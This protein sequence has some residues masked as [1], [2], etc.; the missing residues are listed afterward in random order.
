M[1]RIRPFIAVLDDEPQFCKA[2]GRLLKTHGFEVEMFT[3]GEEL[4]AVCASRLPDCLL[5][6]LHMPRVNG[7]EVLERLVALRLKVPVVVITGHDQPGNADRVRALGA[8]A[9]LLK[10]VNDQTVIDAI[11]FALDRES[12]EN[13]AHGNDRT[14][15]SMKTNESRPLI[16]AVADEE[17]IRN[18][19]AR[20]RHTA[21]LDVET[22]GIG[23]GEL[24]R[25]LRGWTEFQMNLTAARLLSVLGLPA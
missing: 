17:C 1:D 22:T 2:V 24:T 21:V 9:Y 19:M 23:A 4:L 20:L 25:L 12:P 5:L 16:A 13:K 6:D 15:E 7:F 10:P 11:N 3:L 18:A 8:G 14:G